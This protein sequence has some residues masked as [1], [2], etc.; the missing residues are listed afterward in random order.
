V[1]IF[2]IAPFGLV[3]AQM[4]ELFGEHSRLSGHFHVP[5]KHRNFPGTSEFLDQ[6][7]A[8]NKTHIS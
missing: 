5:C 2:N 4:M 7:K 3:R 6:I 8:G 1:V